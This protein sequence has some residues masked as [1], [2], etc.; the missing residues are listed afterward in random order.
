M[1]ITTE[2]TEKIDGWNLWLA[3]NGFPPLAE[4]PVEGTDATRPGFLMPRRWVPSEPEE[5]DK[6]RRYVAWAMEHA[7]M[8]FPKVDQI[9]NIKRRA[10]G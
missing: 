8:S 3:Q 4:L 9:T 6:V 5:Q 1:L 2:E 7:G 10:Q